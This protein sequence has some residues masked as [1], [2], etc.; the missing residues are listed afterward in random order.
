MIKRKSVDEIKE[1]MEVLRN[2]KCL[3]HLTDSEYSLI[4]DKLFLIREL[5]QNEI[6][7]IVK[8]TLIL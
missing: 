4:V 8:D 3:D 6:K 2:W 1:T 7:D 5:G